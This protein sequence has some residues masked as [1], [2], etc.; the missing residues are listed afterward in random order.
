M[1]NPSLN[2]I[3]PSSAAEDAG[4]VT[5][6]ATGT[7]FV[8]SSKI[9]F[10]SDFIPTEFV[11]TG[12]LVGTVES[13]DYGEGNYLVHV[14]ND[15]GGLSISKTFTFTAAGAATSEGFADPSDPD[16]MEDE[17]EAAEEDGDFVPTHSSSKP[18]SKK[19]KK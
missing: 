14:D 19:G 5:F 10:G 1:P 4:T 9:S 13:T 2:S 16:E 6:N 15:T 11:N 3:N 8:P 7:R 18:K 17:I 12:K